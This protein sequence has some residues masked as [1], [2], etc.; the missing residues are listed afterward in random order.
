MRNKIRIGV[1]TMIET[2]NI[3]NEFFKAGFFESN[4]NF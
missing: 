4:Q 3:F 1:T 2:L